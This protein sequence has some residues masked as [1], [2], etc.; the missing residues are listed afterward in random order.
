MKKTPLYFLIL[1]GALIAIGYAHG[2]TACGPDCPPA[3]PYRALDKDGDGVL[4]EQEIAVAAT[5]RQLSCLRCHGET[6]FMKS[7]TKADK[8]GDRQINKDE[9]MVLCQEYAT[10]HTRRKRR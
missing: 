8:D 6:R 1:A 7:I 10:K 9:R 2:S 3:C 5:N 4:N